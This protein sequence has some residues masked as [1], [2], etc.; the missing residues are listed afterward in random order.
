[1]EA[2]GRC[3]AGKQQQHLVCLPFPAQ[4]HVNPML[5]FAIL[6]HHRGFHITFVNTEYNHRRLLRARHSLHGFPGFQFKTI[7]DGLS[8]P[9]DGDEEA[10]CTQDV[11]SLCDSTSKHCLAPFLRL[12][13]DLNSSP[14]VPPVTCV[15]SDN[16]MS[17]GLVAA[18]EIGVAGVSFRP[19]TA[20]SFFCNALLQRFRQ[21]GLIPLK[22]SNGGIG[23]SDRV[24][25]D[26]DVPG[27]STS[28]R[29]RD[30]PTYARISNEVNTFIMSFINT[31]TKRALTKASA[32]I[33]H[34]L[35]SLEH[36]TLESLSAMC[37][38]IYPIAPLHLLIDQLPDH[39][40]LKFLGANL[41]KEDLSC[42]QWLD[43]KAPSSVVY[44]NFGSV[45]V[46]TQRQLMEFAWGL[47]KSEQN[48]LWVVRSDGVMGE[49]SSNS[50]LP[51]EFYEETKGRGIVVRWCPQER[52]LKHRSTGAFLT[53]C[54]WNSMMESISS[55]VPM[56]CWPFF[57][58]QHLNCRLACAEWGVG[59]EIESEVDRDEVE[60][61][62]R[63]VMDGGEKGEEMKVKAREL[64]RKAEEAVGL[65]GSSHLILDQLVKNVF[66]VLEPVS[67]A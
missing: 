11:R 12:L 8:S 21:K 61:V 59:V 39:G 37:P 17:F 52:V 42:L 62:V 3:D 7:P 19:T 35:D 2:G 14:G 26:F 15:V 47:A 46:I 24:L 56:I 51:G 44:V 18:E 9:Q 28:I 5:K 67:K 23:D 1:M 54:G 49:E 38:P 64:K 57:A 13:S 20:C 25:A 4:G 36:D 22:D 53:H 34:T 60:K 48:F 50:A 27:I 41:W 31:E 55:G 6:L 63:E 10:N 45:T 33:F 16:I 32:I 30:L 66:S 58:D 65:G 29:L 43:S 40:S